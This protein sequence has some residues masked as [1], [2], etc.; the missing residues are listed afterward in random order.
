[1]QTEI[2]EKIFF[3]LPFQHPTFFPRKRKK[4]PTFQRGLATVEGLFPTLYRLNDDH[5]HVSLSLLGN[6]AHDHATNCRSGW[7]MS[8]T[9]CRVKNSTSQHS[10]ICENCTIGKKDRN[11]ASTSDYLTAGIAVQAKRARSKTPYLRKTRMI[12]S[13]FLFRVF[14]LYESSI[15]K[16]KANNDWK[17]KTTLLACSNTSK[18][19]KFSKYQCSRV[20]TVLFTG[21]FCV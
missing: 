4:Q 20:L 18:I 12:F 15:L 9:R 3:K 13:F 21:R 7:D 8:L 1:M 10:L 5:C 11:F 2:T 16:K 14:W 19:D 6:T 17:I